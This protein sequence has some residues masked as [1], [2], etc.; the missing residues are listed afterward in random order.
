MLKRVISMALIGAFLASSGTIVSNVTGNINNPCVNES[1]DTQFDF[2]GGFDA[3][4]ELS[5]LS[6][7]EVAYDENGN[8]YAQGYNSLL[9]YTFA[10]GGTEIVKYVLFSCLLS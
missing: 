9:K 10:Y 3:A 4:N 6:R 2:G 8:S 7:N 1:Y 5:W